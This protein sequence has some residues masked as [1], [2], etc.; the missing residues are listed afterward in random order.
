MFTQSSYQQFCSKILHNGIHLMQTRMLTSL[1]TEL[2]VFIIFMQGSWIKST[3]HPVTCTSMYGKVFCTAFL[4]AKRMQERMDTNSRQK[5]WPAWKINANQ[6][7]TLNEG[8]KLYA[9][10]GM[11]FSKTLTKPHSKPPPQ[12]KNK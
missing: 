8:K 7:Q 4:F 1:Q 11:H 2:A 5:G 10:Q 9:T 12:K 3:H 6:R